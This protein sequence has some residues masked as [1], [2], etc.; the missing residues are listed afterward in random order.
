M[1]TVYEKAEKS[2]EFLIEYYAYQDLRRACKEIWKEEDAEWEKQCNYLYAKFEKLAKEEQR[3]EINSKSARIARKLEQMRLTDELV[4][5]I[6]RRN[7][8]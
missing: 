1:E 5:K 4:E 8:T 6:K 3:R 7:G 2:H